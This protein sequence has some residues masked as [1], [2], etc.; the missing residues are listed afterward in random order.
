VYLVTDKSC[1]VEDNHHIFNSLHTP[2]RFHYVVTLSEV[3]IES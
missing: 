2:Q 3:R 1:V